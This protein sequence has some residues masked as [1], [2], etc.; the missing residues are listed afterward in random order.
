MRYLFFNFSYTAIDK[1]RSKLW[2]LTYKFK[3]LFKAFFKLQ[4]FF[5]NIHFSH[6]P[7][8]LDLGWFFCKQKNQPFYWLIFISIY[9]ISSNKYIIG[10]GSGNRT[11]IA[12]LEGWNSTIE[13][14]LH[15]LNLF[16]II[17]RGFLFVNSFFEIN[18]E[19]SGEE[20]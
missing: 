3:S 18:H 9:S 13:L 14:H 1:S 16:Y 5:D 6:H 17:F 11:R 7:F 4:F 19:I 12:S 15:L 10:A 8:I 2:K 20:I